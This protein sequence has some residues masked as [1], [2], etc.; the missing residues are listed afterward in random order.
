MAPGGSFVIGPTDKTGRDHRGKGRLQ[1]VGKH[2]LR[3]AETGEFFLKQGS[4]SPENLLNYVDFDDQPPGAQ[5][6]KTWYGHTSDYDALDASEYTWKGGK[7]TNLLGAIKYLSDKGMNAFSFIP[8]N[9]GGDDK[10]VCPHL[11]KGTSRQPELEHR[12]A[13]RPVRRVADGAMGAHLCLRR[14]E[15]DVSAFQDAGERRTN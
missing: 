3:F 7:G 1:Y 13:S 5:Y 8:F 14:Q 15:G 2:H 12:C 9:I 11:L 6:L 10:N 4:D